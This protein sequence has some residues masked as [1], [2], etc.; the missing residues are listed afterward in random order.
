MTRKIKCPVCR[1]ITTWDNNQWR[2]FCSERCKIIDLGDWASEKHVIAGS[3][4]LQELD[5][6]NS[7]ASSYPYEKEN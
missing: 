1:K 6:E 5:E 3:D 7:I 4:N 2:P